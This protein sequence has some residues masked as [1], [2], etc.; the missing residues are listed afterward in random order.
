MERADKIKIIEQKIIKKFFVE[1][2]LQDLAILLILIKKIEIKETHLINKMDFEKFTK[3]IQSLS[4]DKL[5]VYFESLDFDTLLKLRNYYDDLYYNTGESSISDA[6]YDILFNII[7]GIDEKKK[8]EV[9]YKLRESENRV[10]LP[11]WL[12]SMDKIKPSD[13]D[14]FERWINK[15]P[16]DS[17]FITEKLDGVSC[18]FIYNSEGNKISLYTRGDGKIGADISYLHSY[19]NFIPKRFNIPEGNIV[20]RGEL[21][22][23][24]D[25]WKKYSSK[26][27]NPRNMVSGLVN[28]K[29]IKEGINDIDFIAYEL[30]EENNN[31]KKISEQ[32]KLLKKYG[33]KTAL[34]SDNID[35]VNIEK[36]T[37]LLTEFKKKS[38][39]EIDGIIIQINKEYIRNKSGN[40]EYAFAFKMTDEENIVKAK[41]I[42]V[43]WNLSKRGFLKPRVSIDQLIYKE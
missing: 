32:F 18:L 27:S 6:K 35:K 23:S 19:L 36:L 3:K 11:Y 34:S 22:I 9:G 17:Y 21:I 16:K 1:I 20:V 37:N 42:R 4:S 30:I 14:K 25:N 15:F 8:G 38:S 39:Y 40:P 7:I 33:F 2:S 31:Q 12:G 5:K 43:E 28:S 41:V 10:V 26:Y 13:K 29:T 24:K